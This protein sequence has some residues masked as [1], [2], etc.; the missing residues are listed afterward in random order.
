MKDLI[1]MLAIFMIL[2]SVFGIFVLSMLKSINGELEK[3]NE[4]ENN[5][6]NKSLDNRRLL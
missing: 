5:K 2:S 3:I 4:R 1:A 6:D